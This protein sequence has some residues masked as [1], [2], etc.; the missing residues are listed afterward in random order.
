[1]TG[2]DA[3]FEMVASNTIMPLKMFY[4]HNIATRKTALIFVTERISQNDK[5]L[6]WDDAVA[7]GKE[8][9]RLLEEGFDF[10]DVTVL[11]NLTKAEMIQAFNK[12]QADVSNFAETKKGKEVMLTSIFWIGHTWYQSGHHRQYKLTPSD[13]QPEKTQDGTICPR[14]FGVTKDGEFLALYEYASRIV[15]ASKD[16][17]CIFVLDWFSMHLGQL[18]ATWVKKE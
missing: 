18:N 7:K 16:V 6:P 9:K 2:K 3:S 8:A 4:E 14:T 10:T 17:H 1:M 12:F 5:T 13:A 15:N 11:T